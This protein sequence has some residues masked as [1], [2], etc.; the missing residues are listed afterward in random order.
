[1]TPNIAP[2]DVTIPLADCSVMTTVHCGSRPRTVPA[3]SAIPPMRLRQ[4][5][6]A[7]ASDDGGRPSQPNATKMIARKR[8]KPASNGTPDCRATGRRPVAA[9]SG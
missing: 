2:A 3:E 6:R 9:A 8:P 7:P 4:S 1:M 5:W